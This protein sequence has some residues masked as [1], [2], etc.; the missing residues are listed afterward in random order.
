MRSYCCIPNC[1]SSSVDKEPGLS[2]HEFP[3]KNHFRN[4]WLKVLTTRVASDFQLDE[5]TKTKVCSKHFKE[6]DFSPMCSKR[7]R[8]KGC[9]VPSVFPESEPINKV[10]ELEIV[11]KK[12]F[13]ESQSSCQ[14]EELQNHF[15]NTCANHVFSDDEN[16]SNVSSGTPEEPAKCIPE[17]NET[18]NLSDSPELELS[19]QPNCKTSDPNIT[20]ENNS[21]C[22]TETQ[23]EHSISDV[24]FNNA[25]DGL[26]KI[27][28]Q[29][30][31]LCEFT[32]FGLYVASQLQQMPLEEAYKLKGE[33]QNILTQSCPRSL[34]EP[35]FFSY[36]PQISSD[37]DDNIYCDLQSKLPIIKSNEK[38][39]NQST[40][41][42]SS[43]PVILQSFALPSTAINPN[44]SY[45]I[46]ALKGSNFSSAVYF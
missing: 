40:Q 18:E 39:T 44:S 21:I 22:H 10:L 27:S 32:V 43:H 35:S 24:F 45:K 25:V 5:K 46:Y 42:I 19:S 34:K 26:K 30:S 41:H 37:R 38:D 14:D 17:L 6:T 13:E 11:I 36:K 4:R 12:D 20:S 8:L 16:I 28:A 7:R 9:A 29:E 1:N 23:K 3:S 31:N 2:F 33:I 15:F